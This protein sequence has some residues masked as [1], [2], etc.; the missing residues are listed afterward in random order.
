MS[1][2]QNA[3]QGNEADEQVQGKSQHITNND[4]APVN[5]SRETQD[6]QNMW[7]PEKQGQQGQGQGKQDMGKTGSSQQKDQWSQKDK[8]QDTDQQNKGNKGNMGTGQDQNKKP[9]R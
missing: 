7:G 9:G 8:D 1:G 2:S 4:S 5:A 3:Q 6:P